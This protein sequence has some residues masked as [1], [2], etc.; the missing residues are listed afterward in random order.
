MKDNILGRIGEFE[1]KMGNKKFDGYILLAFISTF[2]N[3]LLGLLV[4]SEILLDLSFLNPQILPRFIVL[5]ASFD[6]IDGKFARKSKYPLSF[7]SKFDTLAD[8]VTFS[9]APS[10]MIFDIFGQEPFLLTMILSGLYFFTSTFRLSRF[11]VGH[12][13]NYYDGIPT[14]VAA[15]FIA[16]W[17]IQPIFDIAFMAGSVAFISCLMIVRLPYSGLRQ[18]TTMF[19]RFFYVFTITM[20][21]LFTYAPNNWMVVLGKIWI[22]YVIYF[23]IIGPTQARKSLIDVNSKETENDSL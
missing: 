16:G 11:M 15:I 21:L 9:V 7:G 1:F 8:Q 19:Q 4:I 23:G 6:V 17:Y 22:G 20:M 3:L 10:L 2:S 18:R 13:Y 12:S 14:P 5:G